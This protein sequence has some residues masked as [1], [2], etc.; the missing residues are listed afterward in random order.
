[1]SFLDK[2]PC[3]I[4]GLWFQ[5]SKLFILPDNMPHLTPLSPLTPEGIALG[6]LLMSARYLLIFNTF[7]FLVWKVFHS[8]YETLGWL[9][10]GVKHMFS[11][12]TSLWRNKRIVEHTERGG[13]IGVTIGIYLEISTVFILKYFWCLTGFWMWIWDW[14]RA[15][16]KS[17]SV[18]LLM[19][20]SAI[21]K[22]T[23]PG[24]HMNCH[25]STVLQ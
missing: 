11:I 20:R 13:E 18:W 22:V 14:Y 9:S 2:I 4:K 8:K 6:L 17:E 7:P 16:R 24:K 3:Q 19:F 5:N 21:Q 10:L 23:S 12:F 1:M 15:L 25:T